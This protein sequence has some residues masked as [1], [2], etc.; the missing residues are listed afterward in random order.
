M[1]GLG[2]GRTFSIGKTATT[3]EATIISQ[4]FRSR[5]QSD[6]GTVENLSCGTTKVKYLLNNP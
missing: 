1:F 3:G 6:G 4:A 5:V 2:Y